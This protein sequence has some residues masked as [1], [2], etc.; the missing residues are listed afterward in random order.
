[1]PLPVTALVG[2]LYESVADLGRGDLDHSALITLY[3]ELARFQL[4]GTEA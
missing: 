2:Q 3:Q 4:G 1:M